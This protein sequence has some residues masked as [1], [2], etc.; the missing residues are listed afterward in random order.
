MRV[1]T[2]QEVLARDKPSTVLSGNDACR[3]LSTPGLGPARARWRKDPESKP[4]EKE[5]PCSKGARITMAS[6]IKDFRQS[7]KAGDPAKSCTGWA[8]QSP[9]LWR[10]SWMLLPTANLSSAHVDL[11]LCCVSCDEKHPSLT[12]EKASS[13]VKSSF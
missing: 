6:S 11:I 7:R 13:W 3:S 8:P 4:K 1:E 5:Q 10:T 2:I 9:R 12:K